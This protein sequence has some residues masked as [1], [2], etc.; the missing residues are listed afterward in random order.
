MTSFG[1]PNKRGK[2]YK[3]SSSS[4][5]W[6]KD[7]LWGRYCKRELKEYYPDSQNLK[8]PL[9]AFHKGEYAMLGKPEEGARFINTARSKS[10]PQTSHSSKKIREKLFVR[11]CGLYYFS[12]IL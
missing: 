11:T 10:R 1:R 2:F 9:L 7:L 8:P 4:K 6:V 12:L 3:G 5:P